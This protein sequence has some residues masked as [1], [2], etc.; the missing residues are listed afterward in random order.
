M[1]KEAVGGYDDDE[2]QVLETLDLHGIA[3][4]IKSIAC[5]NVFIMV[6]SSR[7]YF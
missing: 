1:W 7:I 6:N 3:K 4:Y 5:K 2:L